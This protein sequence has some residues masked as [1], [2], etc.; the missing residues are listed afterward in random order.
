MQVRSFTGIIAAAVIPALAIAAEPKTPSPLTTVPLRISLEDDAAA[1]VQIEI[2]RNSAG[3]ETVGKLENLQPGPLTLDLSYLEPD[4]YLMW[5]S[6]PGYATQWIRLG[7]KNGEATLPKELTLF[8]K[9]YAV[10]RYAV[11]K[12]GK[13]DLDTGDVEEG[14]C[15]VAHCGPMPYFHGDWQIWQLSKELRLDFHRVSEAHG[16]ARPAQD[17]TF[18]SLS[19]APSNDQYK[20]EP[21]MAT[22][23]LLL[24]CRVHGNTAKDECYAKLLI[25]SVTETPPPDTKIVDSRR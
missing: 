12:S 19:T 16:F 7:I 25:E 20:C 6:S 1:P 22:K 18:E 4:S 10:I 2:K 21:I 8:R 3:Q 13:R 14:R 11:N 5:L 23:G 24:F 17:A 15:A 9:R